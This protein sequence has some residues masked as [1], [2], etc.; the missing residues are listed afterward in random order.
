LGTSLVACFRSQETSSK[1][2][3]VCFKPVW[4]YINKLEDR[5]ILHTGD[6]YYIYVN[7]SNVVE[8]VSSEQIENLDKAKIES[9][10]YSLLAKH[11]LDKK[12]RDKANRLISSEASEFI[13]D[14]SDE[15]FIK[16]KSYIE[17]SSS[18][19]AKIS[20]IQIS[21]GFSLILSVL[22]LF[23]YY[24]FVGS[25][26]VLNEISLGAMG[27]VIGALVSILQRNRELK[28]E[29][30]SSVSLLAFQ[31]IT[32]SLLGVIFGSLIVIAAKANIA[33]GLASNSHYAIFI[34]AFVSGINERFVPDLLEKNIN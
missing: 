12:Q 8:I 6:G 28:P 32:R 21:L 18:D 3:V 14:P 13:N 5:D 24:N 2:A 9:L 10:H 4:E 19:N 20:Y 25:S 23:F 33:L 1:S 30:F 17:Q 7:D 11:S 16:S 27:G 34:I 26:T 31:G 22:L 15:C 29:P